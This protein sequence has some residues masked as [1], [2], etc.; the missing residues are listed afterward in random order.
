[1]KHS[2]SDSELLRLADLN[3]VE[4]WCES[5]RWMPSYE[6]VQ[7]QD[8]VL[9]NSASNF[10]VCNPVFN[11]ATEPDE[12]PEAFLERAK[13]FFAKRKPMFSIRLRSH[14]D[15]AII[16]YCKDNKILLV[17]EGPGMVLDE[18]IKKAAVPSG[19]KLRW[20]DNA[21]GVQDFKQVVAEAYQDLGLPKEVSE[22]Y[23][24]EAKR[25]LSPYSFLAVA[26][27][28]GEPAGA[29]MAMLSH[30][31]GGIYWVGTTKKAR[32][33]RLGEYCTREVGNAAFELGARK[34]ILQAS[35]FGEP[36]YLKM[37]YREITKY[38]WFICSS[39]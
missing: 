20:V 6:I 39:K 16:Q 5:S 29:A 4:Y 11:M 27:L 38:P 10:P 13:S 37:G 3:M 33:V 17:A 23:F 24:A 22:S 9:I 14:C 2:M 35:K 30:G 21:K 34:V 18:P 28:K 31:I 15:Q 12:L 25:V 32:G 36:I 19:T 26:Y 8:M 7:Q 1:M